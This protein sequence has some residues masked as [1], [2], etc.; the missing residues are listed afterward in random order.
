KTPPGKIGLQVQLLGR[1]NATIERN[2]AHDFGIQE[3]AW[4]AAH[5]PNTAIRLLPVVTH[6]LDQHT[7]HLPHRAIQFLTTTLKTPLTPVEMDTIEHF[8]EYIQL[9][10]PGC[11]VPDTYRAR[12]TIA[13]EMW[14]FSLDQAAFTSNTIHNLEV[15]TARLRNTA[16]PASEPLSHPCITQRAH[17]H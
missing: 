6:M 2:P 9:F 5:L 15:I 12:T 16:Q 1:S 7:H 17:R 14:Q 8:S 13:T 11:R 10:L 4:A 3:M